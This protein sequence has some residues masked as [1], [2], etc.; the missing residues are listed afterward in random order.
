MQ[1]LILQHQKIME[2]NIQMSLIRTNIKNML[3]AVMAVNQYVSMISLS[4]F[5]KSYLGEEKNF[6]IGI[7]ILCLQLILK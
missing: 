1:I 5:F 4:S 3:L 2:S 7:L 6:F